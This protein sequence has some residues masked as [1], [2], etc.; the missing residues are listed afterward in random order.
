[1]T[2]RSPHLP[3]A[4]ALLA[5]AASLALAIATAPAGAA[6]QKRIVALTPF[7]ANVLANV[8]VRPVAVGKLASANWKGAS[9][10]LKK[11]LPKIKQLQLS[12]PNGPNMEQIAQIDPDVVLTS[13]E[14]R[15]GSQTMRDLAITVREMDATTASQV[16]AKI[17][18]IGN[19]YGSKSL[20][21]RY[22]RQAAGEIAYARGVSKKNPHPIT[23]RPTVLMVLGVGR[24]PFAFLPNSWAG[25]IA[26]A[27]GANLIGAELSDTSGLKRISDEYVVAQNPDVIIAVPHG[28]AT[29]LPTTGQYLKSNPAW[30]STKAAQSGNVFIADDDALLQPNTDV[31]DTIKRLRTAYLQNW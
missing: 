6:S 7:S 17:R 26:K 11:L 29:D 21:A 13:S 1:M 22:A 28:N 12:H 2:Y 27:A 20:T 31:G 8:G 4:L 5:L 25:S 18:A 9:P 14:W 10:K 15:K 19:A 23:R 24:T 30:A 16:P 3:R